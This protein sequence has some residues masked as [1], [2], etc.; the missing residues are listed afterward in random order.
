M[1]AGCGPRKAAKASDLKSV[2]GVRAVRRWPGASMNQIE[3]KRL[4]GLIVLIED[5][6]GGP[7]WRFPG[8]APLIGCDA[9]VEPMGRRLCER[10]KI[11][12]IGPG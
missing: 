9:R 2:G 5:Q 1:R 7:Q 8:S 3:L 4:L 10:F 11:V 12:G 6:P